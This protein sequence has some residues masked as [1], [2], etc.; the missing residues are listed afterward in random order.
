MSELRE[1]AFEGKLKEIKNSISSIKYHMTDKKDY[2]TLNSLGLIEEV[3]GQIRSDCKR[4]PKHETEEQYE[5]FIVRW[6]F[7]LDLN[8][9]QY[10][11]ECKDEE[12]AK[13]TF[14]ANHHKTAYLLGITNMK[15]VFYNPHKPEDV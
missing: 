14:I 3:I 11:I 10:Y 8:T 12:E 7:P 2:S 4:T 9:R 6:K 15:H 13:D 1:C 5:R